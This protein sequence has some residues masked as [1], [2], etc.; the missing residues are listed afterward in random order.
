MRIPKILFAL[1]T[2][3]GCAHQI[4]SDSVVLPK[5]QVKELLHQCS[6]TTPENDD[7][8]WPVPDQV[9]QRVDRDIDKVS[10]LQS[11]AGIAIERP[12]DYF[13]QYVGIAISGRQFVYINAIRHGAFGRT[14][15][16]WKTKAI[17][18]CD[19]GEISWGALYDPATRN[20]SQLAINGRI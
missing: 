12:R 8:F 14:E 1:I 6:R 9:A 11:N 20:F 17:T 13:R 7:G 10:T 15:L 16:P 3:S 5:A 2:L 4:S 19:G 18:I